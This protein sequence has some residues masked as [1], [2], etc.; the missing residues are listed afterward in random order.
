MSEFPRE[1]P[2]YKSLGEKILKHIEFLEKK[3]FPVDPIQEDDVR[4]GILN[5]EALLRIAKCPD[6]NCTNGLT[7]SIDFIGQNIIEDCQ[8]CRGRHRLLEQYQGFEKENKVDGVDWEWDREELN[9][10]VE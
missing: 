2:K 7:E 8:W 10:K 5:L 9:R 6:Q 3:M 1:L 4:D